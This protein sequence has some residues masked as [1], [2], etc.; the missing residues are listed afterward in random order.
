MQLHMEGF[1]PVT[2][3]DF[4]Q[5]SRIY[6]ERRDES[7]EGASTFADGAV[8]DDRGVRIGRISYNGRIWAPGPFKPNDTPI[9]DNSIPAAGAA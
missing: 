2:V 4:A 7:G 8:L 5:A 6:G 9:W 3:A 1:N